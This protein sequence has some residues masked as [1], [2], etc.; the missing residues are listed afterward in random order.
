MREKL[1]KFIDR[2]A[3]RLEEALQ[4]NEIINVF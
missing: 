3:F 1:E 2:V 4:S